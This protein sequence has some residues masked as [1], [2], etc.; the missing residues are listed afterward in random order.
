MNRLNSRS[1][2]ADNT[3]NLIGLLLF[4]MSKNTILTESLSYKPEY[5]EKEIK[6]TKQKTYIIDHL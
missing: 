4:H 3:V 2:L 6:C 1:V 5:D